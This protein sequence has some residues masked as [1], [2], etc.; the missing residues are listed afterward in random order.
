MLCSL[1][2][3]AFDVRTGIRALVENNQNGFLID[4][5]DLP[6]FARKLDL[7]MSDDSLR[8]EMGE[9]AAGLLSN[10]SEENVMNQWDRILRS[11][12]WM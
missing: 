6:Q 9:K 8:V 4:D 12:R 3:V 5:G 10:Y 11:R 2:I 1:P 7:L